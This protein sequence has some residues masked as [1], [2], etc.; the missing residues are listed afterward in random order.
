MRYFSIIYFA[1]HSMAFD[2]RA[3]R[4]YFD[5]APDDMLQQFFSR[6]YHFSMP[7]ALL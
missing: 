4:A 6:I 2:T 3:Q 1:A 7:F 5:A